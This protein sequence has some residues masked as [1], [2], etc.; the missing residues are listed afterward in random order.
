M[1]IFITI[2]LYLIENLLSDSLTNLSI[3]FRFRDLVLGIAL[4]FITFTEAQRKLD[5]QVAEAELGV[6]EATN[7]LLTSNI[8]NLFAI[9]SIGIIIYNLFVK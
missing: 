8:L 1:V 9:Q 6:V 2:A 7:N 3:T 4:G 5:K